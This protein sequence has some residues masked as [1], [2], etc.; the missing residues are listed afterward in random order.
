[1]TYNFDLFLS[2]IN[3]IT[4]VVKKVKSSQKLKIERNHGTS[5][6]KASYRPR[7]KFATS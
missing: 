3:K 4:N 5:Q 7:Q 1:M 6:E 2:Y